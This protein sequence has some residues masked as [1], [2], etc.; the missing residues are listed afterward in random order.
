MNI[1][2]GQ[3]RAEALAERHVVLP[4][5]AFAIT[6]QEYPVR[7]YCVLESVSPPEMAEISQ[8]T[9]LHTKLMDNYERRNWNFCV[10]AIQHLLGRWDGQL[11]SFYQNLLNRVIQ[12]QQQGVTDDWTPVIDRRNLDTGS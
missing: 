8:W 12:Y 6:G 10:Q 2:L 3:D 4:L 9:N 11:D 7:S 5:D 1:V